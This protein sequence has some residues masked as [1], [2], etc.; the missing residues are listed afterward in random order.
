MNPKASAIEN[1]LVAARMYADR[2]KELDEAMGE[3]HT[4]A[5][6]ETMNRMRRD[7]NNAVTE[8]TFYYEVN[9]G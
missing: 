9:R 8:L 4:T 3:V 6:A 5:S 7:A 1:A 2:L